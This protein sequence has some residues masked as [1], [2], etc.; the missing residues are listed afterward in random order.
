M[1]FVVTLWLKVLHGVKK[2]FDTWMAHY[3]HTMNT[4]WTFLPTMELFV[5][6]GVQIF[7][8]HSLLNRHTAQHGCIYLGVRYHL[9]LPR[10]LAYH[11]DGHKQIENK[12]NISFQIFNQISLKASLLFLSLMKELRKRRWVWRMGGRKGKKR[13]KN[14]GEK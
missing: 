7:L 4:L 3:D 8:P 6:L 1:Y 9:R 14:K 2:V 5:H 10:T 11:P 12:I 13:R